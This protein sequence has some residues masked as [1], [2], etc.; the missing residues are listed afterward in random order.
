MQFFAIRLS[1]WGSILIFLI[2]LTI[3]LATDSI[4]L[5]LDA[6]NNLVILAMAVLMGIA[7]RKISQPP[8]ENYNFG[9]EK[10]EPLAALTQSALIIVVC[11]VSL[12]FAIQDIIHVDD[13]KSYDLAAA[14]TFLTLIIG[15]M[16]TLYL[17]RAAKRTNSSL[18]HAASLHWLMDTGMASLIFFGFSLGLIL[19]QLGFTTITPYVDPVMA[20]LFSII[21]ISL[22]LKELK[23]DLADLLD[24]TPDKKV[25]EKV[26]KILGAYKNNSYKLHHL[27]TRRAGQK[28]F[29]EACFIV[30][31]DLSV[32]KT[33]ELAGKIEKDIK[34]YLPQ[35]DIV[36]NFRV[37]NI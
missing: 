32:A 36:I 17:Y 1:F 19:Q 34:S 33:D 14:G 30:P 5:I 37:N 11:L 25:K 24:A 15:V 23:H 29:F 4:T 10:F 7:A 13:M 2:S 26:N 35:S 3:A 18:L 8:D 9:Y 12:F 31:G 27:R 28:H 20:I 22:P 16:I 6:S 21:F